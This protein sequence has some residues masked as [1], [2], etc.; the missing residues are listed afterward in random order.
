MGRNGVLARREEILQMMKE[1]NCTVMVIV[2]CSDLGMVMMWRNLRLVR[3]S[4]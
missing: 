4:S 2:E 3:A 1:I